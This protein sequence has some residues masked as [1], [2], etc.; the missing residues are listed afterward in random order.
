MVTSV[1]DSTNDLRI[2]T[3]SSKS[4]D[5][6]TSTKKKSKNNKSIRIEKHNSFL[7]GD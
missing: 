1:D 4:N 3:N 6:L 7:V 5:R 2:S